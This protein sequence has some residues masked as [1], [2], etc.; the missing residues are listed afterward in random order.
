MKYWIAFLLGINFC[1]AQTDSLNINAPWYRT[2]L[3]FQQNP[4]FTGDNGKFVV[5]NSTKFNLYETNFNDALSTN[6]SSFQTCFKNYG[7]GINYAYSNYSGVLSNQ[8]LGLNQ[9]Y[10]I[11]IKKGH[12]LLF[13]F[14][15]S[16][17]MAQLDFSKLTFFDQFVSSQGKIYQTQEPNPNPTVY[18]CNFK[19]GGIYKNQFGF[20]SLNIQNLFEPIVAF[21]DQVGINKS[22]SLIR[23]Y[24]LLAGLKLY[25]IN[26]VQFYA[27]LKADINNISPYEFIGVQASYKSKFI[28]GIH[29][30]SNNGLNMMLSY[31]HPKFR[32]FAS[33]T[34]EYIFKNTELSN[35]G[36][37]SVGLTYQIKK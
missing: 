20:I 14:S 16:I 3:Q 4:A 28:G 7:I 12:F 23:N 36:I 17:N 10:K 15:V 1:F 5:S 8:T 35:E 32:V 19:A 11:H 9:S 34:K 21:Y 22:S 24:E 13:G 25:K 26:D 31:Y 6:T 29:Y 27:N 30:T 33:Y 18:Y 37:L 2:N